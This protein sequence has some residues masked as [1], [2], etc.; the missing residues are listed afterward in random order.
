LNIDINKTF[1]FSNVSNFCYII[2]DRFILQLYRFFFFFLDSQSI[3]QNLQNCLN[4]QLQKNYF[5]LNIILTDKQFTIDNINCIQKLQNCIKEQLNFFQNC[6]EIIYTIFLLF[7][8]FELNQ[9]SIFTNNIYQYSDFIQSRLNSRIIFEI[10]SRLQQ[11]HW[12]VIIDKK[13]LKYLKLKQNIYKRCRYYKIYIE[14]VVCYLTNLTTVY[15]QSII[16]KK[17]D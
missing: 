6:T 5:R 1:V 8:F 14:V 12:T 15:F 10:L 2:F 13:I 16:K 9:I 7:L 4:F 11:S 3:W 17:K